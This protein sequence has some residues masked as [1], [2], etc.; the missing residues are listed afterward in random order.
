MEKHRKKW[1]HPNA[2]FSTKALKKLRRMLIIDST[3][4]RCMKEDLY[5]ATARISKGMCL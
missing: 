5:Y 1:Y 4:N 3:T 2:L